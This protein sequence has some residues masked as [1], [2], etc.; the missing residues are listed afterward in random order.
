M[1]NTVERVEANASEIL[2]ENSI[3][4]IYINDSM[5][6]DNHS[7]TK[8]WILCTVDF[9][10]RRYFLTHGLIVAWESTTETARLQDMFHFLLQTCDVKWPSETVGVAYKTNDPHVHFVWPFLGKLHLEIFI[11][12]IYVHYR[13]YWNRFITF[14][15]HFYVK[16]MKKQTLLS[17]VLH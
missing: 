14:W 13:T 12:V 5:N 4:G 17:V 16:V 11:I 9:Y 8:S 2:K 6:I 10:F 15:W 7:F 3:A 1:H